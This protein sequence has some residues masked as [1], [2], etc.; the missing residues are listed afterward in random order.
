MALIINK[1]FAR[2]SFTGESYSPVQRLY[3]A[4][5]S[6]LHKYGRTLQEIHSV[7]LGSIIK[8][9]T[10][11]CEL[12]SIYS[13]DETKTENWYFF[14][15]SI[16]LNMASISGTGNVQPVFNLGPCVMKHL[17]CDIVH[18]SIIYFCLS[19]HVLVSCRHVP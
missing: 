3:N 17:W 8:E 4:E 2:W 11:T 6:N 12:I 13:I 16:N 19:N 1:Y 5:L 9:M 15:C 18:S 14:T 10:V 7:L